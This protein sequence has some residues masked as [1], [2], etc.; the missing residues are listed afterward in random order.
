MHAEGLVLEQASFA[1]C[2]P[3]MYIFINVPAISVMEWHPFSAFRQQV[4]VATFLPYYVMPTIHDKVLA[5]IIVLL[6]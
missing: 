1:G 2:R 4:P 3:G 5:S 6:H